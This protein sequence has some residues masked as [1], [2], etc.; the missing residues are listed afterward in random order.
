[1]ASLLDLQRDF[2]A[3]LLAGDGPPPPEVLGGPVPAAARM[4]I[5]RNNVIGNLTGVLRLTYPAILRL[6]GA[7]F[8]TAAAARFIAAA[9]PASADLYEYGAEFPDFLG[10]FAPAGGLVYLADVARLE[11]AVNRALHAPSV[12]ALDAET[13]LG[14]PEEQQAEVRLIA[15][16]SLS[17]LARRIRCRRSGKRC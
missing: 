7:D 17:L 10:A 8:F 14:V 15:H 16:P 2:R 13:L 9:P 3:A 12:P 11:W 6:V 5:Y 4:G 1:M